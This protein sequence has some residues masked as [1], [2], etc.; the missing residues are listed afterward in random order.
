M[1]YHV[2]ISTK[3]NPSNDEVRLDLNKEQLEER[4][5]VPYRQ[6]RPIVIGGKT[7]AP[8]DLE[9]I[10][11]NE[12]SEE[13]DALRPQI[14]AEMDRM[15]RIDSPV[16]HSDDWY[17][18]E[19]GNNVTDNF[20]TGPPGT[21]MA[22]H[23]AEEVHMPEPDARNVFVVHGHDEE[24][25]H[26]VARVLSKLG[27]DQIILHERANQGK[28]VIE[29]FEKNADVQFAV[30]LLSPD[31]MAYPLSAS[32]SNAKPRARQNVI[33]ELGYFVGRLTR[34]CVFALKREDT[35]ELPSD[36]SGVVYTPYDT[37]G[38]WR[39][40]LVRELKAAGY[41]VDANALI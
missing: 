8:V 26:S 24:M 2:R 21:G 10:R 33:L 3:S 11:I 17:V 9:R 36:F 23:H 18:T 14:W 29:K 35:L 41:D 19:E 20:I 38:Q 6:G 1:P 25:K 32:P 31:D 27:M 28:T 7:V 39:F 12:T 15:N 13:S 30:V 22:T 34:E 4:F 40:E 5:L 16:L 37:A